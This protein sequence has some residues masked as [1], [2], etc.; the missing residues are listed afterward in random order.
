M[1][2]GASS[3]ESGSL[4]P[5]C[6]VSADAAVRH[7]FIQTTKSL[8]KMNRNGKGNGA[9][10]SKWGR[11][12]KESRKSHCVMVRFDN[13]EWLKF[14]SMHEKSGVYAR[15]VFLKAHFFRQPFRVLVTDR[16]LLDYCTK[17]SAFHAQ[18]RMVGNNYNQVLRELRCHFSEKKAM[19][20]LYRLEKCTGELAALT[21]QVM[22]LSREFRQKLS[23][24]EEKS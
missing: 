16:T 12:P 6:A 3:P 17:L 1:R 23:E 15:A 24:K 13:E 19:A 18:Y 2:G 22:E 9:E 8:C 20:L 14:L 7:I 5:G 10:G 11:H 4:S 21:Q